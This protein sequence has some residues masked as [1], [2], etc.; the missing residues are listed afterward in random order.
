MA[1]LRATG[2]PAIK[3]RSSAAYKAAS[4]RADRSSLPEDDWTHRRF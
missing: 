4:G 3:A 1:A 2:K